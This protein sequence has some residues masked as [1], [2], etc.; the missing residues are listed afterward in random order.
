ML[1]QIEAVEPSCGEGVPIME[2]KGQRDSLPKWYKQK[3]ENGKLQEF[4][5][6]HF[7]REELKNI[8]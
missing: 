4:E 1:F 7:E 3:H 8:K 5:Q 6:K 2:Y